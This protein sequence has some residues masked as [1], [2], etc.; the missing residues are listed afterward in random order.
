[1]KKDL[2]YLRKKA[3]EH[4]LRIPMP[5]LRYICKLEEKK[6]KDNICYFILG[7]VTT[8]A[9]NLIYLLIS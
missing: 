1:M 4:Y 7:V 8:V 5:V 9:G 6:Y 3:E 2:E